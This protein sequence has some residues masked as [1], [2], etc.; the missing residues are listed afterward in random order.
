MGQI[1]RGPSRSTRT[2]GRATS[3][4]AFVLQRVR[5]RVGAVSRFASVGAAK[6]GEGIERGVDAARLAKASSEG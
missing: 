5:R 3:S 2:R 1:P 6:T 4:W